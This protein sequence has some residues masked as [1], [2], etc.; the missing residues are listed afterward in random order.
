MTLQTAM[1]HCTPGN[2]ARVLTDEF[3]A[4]HIAAHPKVRSVRKIGFK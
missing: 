2:A 4:A 3:V 1:A